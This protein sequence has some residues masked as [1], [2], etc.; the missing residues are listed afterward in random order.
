MNQ[1]QSLFNNAINNANS[2]LQ[3]TGL[4]LIDK[5]DTNKRFLRWVYLYIAFISCNVDVLAEIAWVIDGI[6]NGMKSVELCYAAPGL[7]MSFLCNIKA[8]FFMRNERHVKDLVNSLR[9]LDAIND[10]FEGTREE[11][12]IETINRIKIWKIGIDIEKWVNRI[13][14]FTFAMI[15]F[16]VICQ[17]YFKNG[18]IK[19]VMPFPILFPFDI[20]D[21]R[22]W[23]FMYIRQMCSG[24]FF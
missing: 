19:L 16:A 11:V 24:N 21:I 14:I 3:V 20:F 5:K 7:T 2:F 23:P 17:S 12:H 1:D 6:S 15:P 10:R 8:F 13:A 9:K 18:V 4:H 22:I